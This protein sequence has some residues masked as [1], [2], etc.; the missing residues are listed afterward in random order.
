MPLLLKV[1]CPFEI[2]LNVVHEF[3]ELN[4]KQGS[5]PVGCLPSAAVTVVGGVPT[6]GCTCLGGVYLPRECTYNGMYC[7]G[8]YLPGAYLSR[9]VYLLGVYLPRGLPAQGAVSAWG[10]YMPGVCVCP[11]PCWDIHPPRCG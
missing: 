9:G 5:I 6:R 1:L 4:D 10:V 11:C 8:V 3:A 7:L 2:S